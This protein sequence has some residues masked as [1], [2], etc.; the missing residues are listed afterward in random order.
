M[1]LALDM[2]AAGT[3]LGRTVNMIGPA[4]EERGLSQIFIAINYAGVSSEEEAQVRFD[5]A[6]EAMLASEPAQEDVPVRAPSGEIHRIV[7]KNLLFGMEVAEATLEEIYR[8]AE[9]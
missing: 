6:V 1:S 7:E 8:L 3:S 2:I 4:G 9:V 5:D